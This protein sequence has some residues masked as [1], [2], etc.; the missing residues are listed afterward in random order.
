MYQQ[1]A[2]IVHIIWGDF[3]NSPASKSDDM[4]L[5]S[6]EQCGRKENPTGVLRAS[7]GILRVRLFT[8]SL[9]CRVPGLV[10]GDGCSLCTRWTALG[11]WSS[12]RGGGCD[13]KTNKKNQEHGVTRN[14]GGQQLA[15]AFSPRFAAHSPQME[16]G[17][18]EGERTGGQTHEQQAGSTPCIHSHTRKHWDR[19]RKDKPLKMAYIHEHNFNHCY[20]ILPKKAESVPSSRNCKSLRIISVLVKVIL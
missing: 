1:E 5:L 3:C 12:D 8:D 13:G 11:S 9:R 2:F 17:L 15:T 19:Q 14:A 4:C 7:P 20:L 16:S 10:F 18:G 6:H